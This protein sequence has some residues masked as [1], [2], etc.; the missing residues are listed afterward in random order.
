[1]VQVIPFKR[2]SWKMKISEIKK[3]LSKRYFSYFK[4]L[5][6]NYKKKYWN[7]KKWK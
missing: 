5:I 6:D 1:M 4:F 7:V 3:R 2:E